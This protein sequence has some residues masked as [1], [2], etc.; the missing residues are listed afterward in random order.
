L[1]IGD[2]LESCKLPEPKR[3][4]SPAF[5]PD[6]IGWLIGLYIAEGSR[7]QKMIQISGHVL[8][9][10]YRISKLKKIV[11]GFGSDLKVHN[12]I[13]NASQIIFNWDDFKFYYR[14]LC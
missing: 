14:F 7:S 8:E 13:G 1:K 2:L 4:N 12:Y 11:E 9:D 6:E 3:V 10:E 5:I